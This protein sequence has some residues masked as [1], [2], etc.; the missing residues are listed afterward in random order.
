MPKRPKRRVR[1]SERQPLPGARKKGPAPADDLMYVTVVVR[2]KEQVGSRAEDVGATPPTARTYLSREEL[3]ESHG[4]DP[5]DLA[6]VEE[7][8]KRNGLEVVRTHVAR[9]SVI[10]RGPVES[11]RTG[12]GVELDRWDYSGGNYRGR[13]GSV[14]VPPELAQVVEGVFGL[15]DRPSVGPQASGSGPFYPI[16]IA[17]LYSFPAATDGTGQTIAMLQFGGGFRE[18]D[19]RT[20]FKAL[21]LPVPKVVA[22]SVDGAANTPTGR[23]TNPYDGEV[24]LDIQVAGAAAPGATIVVYF[25]PN[26]DQGYIDAVTKAVHDTENSPTIISI[27]WGQAEPRW[28]EQTMR[29]VDAAFQEAALIGVTV[30]CSV[31]DSGSSDRVAG[32]APHV[33]FPASSPHV[34]GCGGT[35]LS[36]R[37]GSIDSETVWNNPDGGA[38]GGGVSAVFPLPSWQANAQV[39][40]STNAALGAGRGVP[41]VAGHADPLGGYRFRVDGVDTSAGG[42]SAVAPLWAGLLARV[43]ERLGVPV[44]FVNP[45]LYAQLAGTDAFRDI[46]SGNNGAYEAGAGWDPCTGLGSPH[47]ENL[48]AG[49]AKLAAHARAPAPTVKKAKR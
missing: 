17:Q 3:A 44:G 18:E 23:S 10:L 15:D 27:S 5:A 33:D 32:G 26:T 28:T 19:L 45:L 1:G 25:A 34:L 4:A 29:A 9:R 12:F 31:G 47:G 41:D 37:N 20:Y 36:A 16:E 43:N 6:R 49:L 39:P 21:K 35:T 30:C 13:T 24:M 42:T 40:A 14:H 38:T 22:V 48:V 8:A 7:F 11:F 46:T 2:P